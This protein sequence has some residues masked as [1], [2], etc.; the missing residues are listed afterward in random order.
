MSIYYMHVEPVETRRG[1]WISQSW[2]GD[3]YIS[4]P[5]AIPVSESRNQVL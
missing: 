4:I 2:G 3:I 1:H 5:P